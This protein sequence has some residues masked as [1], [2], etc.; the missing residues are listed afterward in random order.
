MITVS[1]TE[2]KANFENLIAQV[3]NG[4][5]IQLTRWKKPVARLVINSKIEINSSIA[6]LSNDIN[7]VASSKL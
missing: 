7:I 6:V 5:E 2:A 3:E 4:T 1:I